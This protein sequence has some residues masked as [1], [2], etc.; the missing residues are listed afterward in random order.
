MARFLKASLRGDDITIYGDGSQTRT[1]CYID[2][3]IDVTLSA[4]ENNLGVNETINLGNAV[5]TSIK[6]LAE[7]C[8]ELTQSKSKIV[9]LPAL[10]EGDMTRRQ[11]DITKMQKILNRPLTTLDEGMLKMINYYKSLQ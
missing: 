1:F 2:D 11:P 8:I 4:L 9:H 3:N 5:E 6:T 7:K 10:K